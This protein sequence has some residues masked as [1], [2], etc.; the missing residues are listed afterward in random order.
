MKNYKLTNL[1]SEEMAQIKSCEG[2][3]LVLTEHHAIHGT[4]QTDDFG[5]EIVPME[6]TYSCIVEIIPDTFE[7]EEKVRRFIRSLSL[8]GKDHCIDRFSREYDYLLTELGISKE[9]RQRKMPSTLGEALKNNPF[10]KSIRESK[11]HDK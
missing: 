11:I 9:I 6:Y 8:S 1:T 3:K 7:K 2:L 10:E 4:H 5:N